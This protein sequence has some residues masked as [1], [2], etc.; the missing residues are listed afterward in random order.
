MTSLAERDIKI[1]ILRQVLK[2]S[3]EYMNSKSDTIQTISKDNEFLIDV[4]KDYH[5]YNSIIKQQKIK[6]MELFE[7]LNQYINTI[8]DTMSKTDNILKQSENQK[9]QIMEE[10]K[11]LKK[12]I[13]DII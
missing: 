3:L 1:D 13:D 12:E 10:I 2:E 7:T 8:S 9:H 5:T 11:S 6:Q 4:A